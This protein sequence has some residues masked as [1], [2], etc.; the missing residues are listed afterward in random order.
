MNIETT[1]LEFDVFSK[2]EVTNQQGYANGTLEQYD[3]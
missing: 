3:E 2:N 1:F